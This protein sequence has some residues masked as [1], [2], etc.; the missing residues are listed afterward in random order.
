MKLLILCLFGFGLVFAKV[1]PVNSSISLTSLAEIWDTDAKSTVL[2]SKTQTIT[3]AQGTSL[4]PLEAS[5][6]ALATYGKDRRGGSQRWSA[7]FTSPAELRLRIA[8]QITGVRDQKNGVVAS[9][10][11]RVTG[12]NNG[13]YYTFVSDVPSTLVIDYTGQT[14][15]P[16]GTSL[17]ITVQ[18]NGLDIRYF[19]ANLSGRIVYAVDANKPYTTFISGF[20][21][22]LGAGVANIDESGEFKVSIITGSPTASL[23]LFA[24]GGSGQSTLISTN[25]ANPFKVLVKDENGSPAKGVPVDFKAPTSGPSGTFTSS[26][27][28]ILTDND[29]YA[30]TSTFRANSKV[31]LYEVV[32]SAGGISYGFSLN[33]VSPCASLVYPLRQVSIT[34]GGYYYPIDASQTTF[35]SVSQ[36]VIV[37]NT[38]TTPIQRPALLVEYNTLSGRPVTLT[39]PHSSTECF[40]PDRQDIVSLG[41]VLEAGETKSFVL[42]YRTEG[43]SGGMHTKVTAIGGLP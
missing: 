3:D 32:A 18:L 42:V 17:H 43:F 8:D 2:D 37:R 11:D 35:A 6:S 14:N 24:A 28:T 25:F 16:I 41:S 5:T 13:F 15:Q 29:G 1:T 10:A 31:G 9:G 4:Y 36:A 39:S 19:A 22:S 26:P 33:N 38:G 23:S 12:K 30:T 7:T 21:T 40:P 34:L 20:M 27:T